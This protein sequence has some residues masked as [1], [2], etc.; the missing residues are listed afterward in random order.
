MIFVSKGGGANCL[1]LRS[2]VYTPSWPLKLSILQVQHSQDHLEELLERRGR[3]IRDGISG[4]PYTIKYHDYCIPYFQ[5]EDEG[6]ETNETAHSD[7]LTCI[8]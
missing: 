2:T 5:H 8:V 4:S 1:H 6:L 7:F 3:V